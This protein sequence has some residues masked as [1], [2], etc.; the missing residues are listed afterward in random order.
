MVPGGR[1]TFAECPSDRGPGGPSTTSAGAEETGAD[2]TELLQAWER[3]EPAARDHLF[4][5]VYPELRRIA[6]RQLAGRGGASLQPTDLL[7]ETY[8]RV[9]GQ[10]RLSWQSRLQFF[11]FAAQVARQVLVDH[12]RRRV[13]LKRGKGLHRVSLDEERVAGTGLDVDILALD[14]ALERLASFDA[15]AARVVELRFFAGLTL[16]EIAAGLGLGEAT[17]H[18]RWRMARAWLRQEL[19]AEG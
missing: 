13:S 11:A 18:R 14:Q 7:H 19:E 6:R 17:V 4:S 5:R 2:I 1:A 9:S 15:A 8:L 3:G 10:E 16:P 12:H